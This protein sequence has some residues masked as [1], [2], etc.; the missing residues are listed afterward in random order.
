MTNKLINAKLIELVNKY[1]ETNNVAI[2]LLK[3][4]IDN[5]LYLVCDDKT[6]FVMRVGKRK[7]N[8][9][10]NFEVELLNHLFK[11]R[12]PVP[13]IINTVSSDKYI[14]Q[15]DGTVVVCFE[16]IEGSSYEVLSDKKPN[17]SIVKQAG[18]ALGKFHKS[19]KSF[20]QQDPKRR[21]I[22]TE[23]DRILDISDKLKETI[24][25]GRKFLNEIEIYTKWAHERNDMSGIIHND[26]GPENIMVKEGYLTSI[27]DFD[28][29][30]PGPF[31]K[32][33]GLALA[34]W[35]FPDGLENHWQEIIDQFLIGY[36]EY[37]PIKLEFD[38]NLI[39]WIN[40]CCL[41]DTAT[42][43]ADLPKDDTKIVRVLQCRRYKKFL[44]FDKLLSKTDAEK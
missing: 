15:N 8:E 36:N 33:V 22:Y 27:I 5:D 11:D 4:G 28:W 29:A 44:Y 26:Y 16:F 32:D 42:F 1:Y 9:T 21:T 7:L 19:S 30:G 6:K 23:F 20:K 43:F 18:E 3:E 35:S 25:G 12:V 37:S 2:S 17:S 41:S 34:L 39:K 38:D 24:D 31:A 40:F 10:V 13:K 14:L